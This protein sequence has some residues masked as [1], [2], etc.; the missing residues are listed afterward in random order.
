MKKIKKITIG[1]VLFGTKYLDKSLPSLVNQN[2]PNIEYIFRD[3]EEGKYSAYE[4]IK[5]SLPEVFKKVKIIK[6]KNLFHSGGHN[7]II[8][9]MSGEY[10][11]CCSNDMLYPNNFVS[12]IIERLE[13][14]PS[15][16][17]ATCKIMKWD[18]LH[19]KKTNI[20]DSFGIGATQY[21]HFYDIGQGEEDKG[22]YNNLKEIF[23]VSGALCVLSKK[24]LESI[25][26]YNEKTKHFEYFDSLIHYKNDV[27]LS[28]RL[29]WAEKKALL[30]QA[31]CVYHDRQTAKSL[32]KPLFIKQSSFLGEKILM[33]KNY[34]NKFSFGV[35]IKTAIYHFLKT[36]FLLITTPSLFKQLKQ[37]K[38]LMP[39][40]NKK[41][42]AMKKLLSNFE[43][44]KMLDNRLFCNKIKSPK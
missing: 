29:R 39:E 27:D 12:K 4:Y 33:K 14:N 20:I 16:S 13:K 40:I 19:N 1:V 11:F 2:Y 6:G 44:H 7:E 24:A 9:R 18:Y 3:H 36:A 32:N 34:S 21:H 22:Q 43:Q 31:V 30:I 25:K 28:Y 37:F 38:K 23:G 17:F 5:N 42:T 26:F 8:S 35:R 10:Y 41:K 15:F